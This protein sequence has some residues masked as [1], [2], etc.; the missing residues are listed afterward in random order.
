[1]EAQNNK[2]LKEEYVERIVE[3][4]N[5]CEDISLLDMILQLLIKSIA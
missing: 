5:K 1:M 2:T 3:A 4:L